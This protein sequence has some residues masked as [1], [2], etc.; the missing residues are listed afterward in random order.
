MV[1]NILFSVLVFVSLGLSAQITIGV[2]VLPSVGDSLERMQ[3]NQPM[4]IS[5]GISGGNQLWDFSRLQAPFVTTS[6]VLDPSEGEDGALF[7]TANILVKSD[8]FDGYFRKESGVYAQLGVSSPLD[9]L[10]ISGII[11]RFQPALTITKVPMRFQDTGSQLSNFRI[12]FSSNDLPAALLD[13]LPI[14][15]DSLRLGQA[16]NIKTQVDAWGTLQLPGGAFEVL[17]LKREVSVTNKIEALLPFLGWAD[18]TAL[19][20]DLLGDFL[21]DSEDLIYEFYANGVVGPVAVATM[22]SENP[23]QIDNVLYFGGEAT[24]SVRYKERGK[25]DAFAYPNPSMGQ[26]RIQ[27]VNLPDDV[28]S[29]HVYNIMGREVHTRKNIKASGTKVVEI[30]L[31]DQPKGTY[32]YAIKNSRGQNIL[33]KRFILIKP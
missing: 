10:G 1:K 8:F 15:P 5:I 24:T 11:G 9:A 21:E 12:T 7:P 30:A 14:R 19:V 25:L 3:D 6:Y 27:M 31:F 23:D 28:Y 33:S 2:S 26:L 29:I 18:I 4:G 16:N 22:S 32:L 13:Q 17:R 20:G